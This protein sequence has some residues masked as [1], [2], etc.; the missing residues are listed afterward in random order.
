M[1]INIRDREVGLQARKPARQRRGG[2]DEPHPEKGAR[3][4]QEVRLRGGEP[5]AALLD[6]ADWYDNF[7]IHSTLGYMGPAEFREAGLILS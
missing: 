5:R 6:W 4:G 7:R 2:V 1:H 3:R